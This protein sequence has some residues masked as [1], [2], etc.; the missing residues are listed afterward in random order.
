M[1]F[2]F[3][4]ED[5]NECTGFESDSNQTRTFDRVDYKH[6]AGI[7]EGRTDFSDLVQE[8]AIQ[9]NATKASDKPDVDNE[10]SGADEDSSGQ[11]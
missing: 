3:D 5:V 7:P 8:E 2:S 10:N 6:D 4:M 9:R 11:Q 1:T